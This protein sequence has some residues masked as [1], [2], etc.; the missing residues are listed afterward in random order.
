[1]KNNYLNDSQIDYAPFFKTLDEKNITQSQ[2]VKN[3]DVSAATLNRMRHNY[4]MTLAAVGHV[5]NVI[6]IDDID[7]V[8]RLMIK[9]DEE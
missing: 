7:D 5:M 4:N 1:M 8:F 3:Y 2:F 6:G 9:E